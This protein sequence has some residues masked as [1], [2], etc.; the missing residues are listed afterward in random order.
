MR[1]LKR[2]LRT[3]KYA[4]Y[5]GKTAA[6]EN[7]QDAYET[8]ETVITYSQPVSLE[9]NVS[10][11]RGSV[12]VQMFGDLENYDKVILTHDMNCPIDE[13]SILFVDVPGEAD[14]VTGTYVYDY[15]VRR[16]A[17][18]LNVIAYAVSHV[19]ASDLSI[20]AVPQPNDTVEN[21]EQEQEEEQGD[22]TQ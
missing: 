14:P 13:Q 2:N 7:T 12:L 21:G 16:V 11:A 5:Q 6:T 19:D 10:P 8:G 4:L 18:S 20:P 15:I 22:D 3:I 17:K 9:C 1:L